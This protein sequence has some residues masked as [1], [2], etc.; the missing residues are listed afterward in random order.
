MIVSMLTQL[1]PQ[2][3][4]PYRRLCASVGLPY[5]SFRRWKHRLAQGHPP[6]SKPGP[7][8]V[9]PLRLEELQVDLGGLRSGRER[10]PGVG[11]LYRQDQDP[12]SRRW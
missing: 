7:H 10:T 6:I 9:G 1:K 11:R 2:V 8:K 12:I 4:W 5:A 3:R